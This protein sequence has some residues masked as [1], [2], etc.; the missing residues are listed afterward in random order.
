M[1]ASLR[2]PCLIPAGRLTLALQLLRSYR[3]WTDVMLCK[4]VYR[5]D[6]AP[7]C[8]SIAIRESADSRRSVSAFIRTESTYS[9]WRVQ[10]L[11]LWLVDFYRIS[12]TRQAVDK[13]SGRS[14][15]SSILSHFRFAAKLGAPH[16]RPIRAPATSDGYLRPQRRVSSITALLCCRRLKPS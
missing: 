16:C 1:A 5:G 3:S 12:A 13:A 10:M 8:Y 6:S 4:R 9:S 7:K 14:S 11:L 2:V 15:E